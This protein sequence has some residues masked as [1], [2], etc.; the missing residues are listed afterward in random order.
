M[1]AQ[2]EPSGEKGPS[3]PHCREGRGA[4]QCLSTRAGNPSLL[5][6]QNLCAGR[7]GGRMLQESLFFHLV[8]EKVPPAPQ[9][10]RGTA[11][12]ALCREPFLASWGAAGHLPTQ[13]YSGLC[14]NFSFCETLGSS[15]LLW[16]CRTS[17]LGVRNH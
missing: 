3:P 12:I 1:G 13:H 8:R 10:K 5:H 14:E 7:S 11:G 16:S 17:S 6:F 2:V 9:N 4:P 15:K